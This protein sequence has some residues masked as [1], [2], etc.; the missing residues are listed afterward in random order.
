MKYYLTIFVA[1]VGLTGCSEE[2]IIVDCERVVKGTLEFAETYKRKSVEL[3]VYDISREDYRKYV[4]IDTKP[5]VSYMQP[6]TPESK[7]AR[8]D[9]LEMQLAAF[10]QAP[11]GTFKKQYAKLDFTAE[12]SLQQPVRKI[13]RCENVVSDTGDH[14]YEM[15]ILVNGKTEWDY[16][17]APN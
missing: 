10:D 5:K 4:T 17:A 6:T 11:A 9:L 1:A 7:K 2:K 12:N 14:R 15:D 3:T 8:N 13:V 16:K